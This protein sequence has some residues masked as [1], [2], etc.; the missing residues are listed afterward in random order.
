MESGTMVAGM[1]ANG[2]RVGRTTRSLHRYYPRS[3]ASGRA[4][5][6]K[7]ITMTIK[8]TLKIESETPEVPYYP[9]LS[10]GFPRTTTTLDIQSQPQGQGTHQ[11]EVTKGLGVQ[12]RSR[13]N[14]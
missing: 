12:K 14:E 7:D 6:G 11:I 1:M 2:T 13:Q 5:I 3:P 10:R 8:S 4:K 9:S